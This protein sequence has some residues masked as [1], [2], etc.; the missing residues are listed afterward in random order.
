MI[1][2]LVYLAI[3]YVFSW[4]MPLVLGFAIA[5]ALKPFTDFICKSLNVK[6]KFAAFAAVCVF[7]FI[8]FSL[9]WL[10]FAVIFVQATNFFQALPGIYAEQI[11]PVLKRLQNLIATSILR[12]SPDLTDTVDMIFYNISS[13]MQDFAVKLSTGFVNFA[14]SIAKK[15]PVY[16][17]AVI[18]TI[19]CSFLICLDYNA[20]TYFIIKQFSQ[21]TR[22]ILYDIKDFLIG[23]LF[24][25]L[26]AYVIIMAITFCELCV[27]LWALRVKYAVVLAMIIAFLDIL[28]VLG[29]GGILI[30]YAI[31]QVLGQNYPMGLGLVILYLIITAVRNIIEPRI[32]GKTIGLHPI[33]TLTAMFAGL[34]IFGFGGVVIA[35]IT[36]LLLKYL[37][38][39]G[40]IKLYKK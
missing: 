21:K 35:P 19:I 31:L 40:A 10:L 4:F 22:Y 30:P 33:I 1:T 3:A 8:L 2:A 12:I 13:T 36:V 6:R 24:K 14:V 23:T 11:S 34:K 39:T 38:E 29:S 5:A 37:N 15:L 28:P 26:K 17:I 27:G 9:L 7:Y 20:V 25:M 18:F 32:V 16:L